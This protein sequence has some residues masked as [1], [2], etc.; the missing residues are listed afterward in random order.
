MKTKLK[1]FI[2]YDLDKE[3]YV[4]NV[5][6]GLTHK[7]FKAAYEKTQRKIVSKTVRVMS[8]TP[9]TNKRFIIGQAKYIELFEPLLIEDDKPPVPFNGTGE[10]LYG[11]R[12]ES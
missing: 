2:V 6:G 12:G 8:S 3:E 5:L 1:G 7:S 11:V 4:K 9:A 10:A